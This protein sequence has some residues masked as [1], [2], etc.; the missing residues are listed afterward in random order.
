MPAGLSAQSITNQSFPIGCDGKIVTYVAQL[1][2][3]AT[4]TL[5]LRNFIQN[6]QFTTPQAVLIDNIANTADVSLTLQIT[7][8]K[9]TMRAGRQGWI[10]IPVI[11]GTEVF[12]FAS[13]GG[14]NVPFFFVNIPMPLGVWGE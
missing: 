9:I 13:S 3:A 5:D 12:T 6:G 4:D 2:S 10:P 1:A 14:V 11:P 7:N 8:V